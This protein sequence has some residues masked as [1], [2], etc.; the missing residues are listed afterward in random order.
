MPDM[1]PLM[2]VPGTYAVWRR[3]AQ[4]EDP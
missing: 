2:T 4:V 3:L 1:W